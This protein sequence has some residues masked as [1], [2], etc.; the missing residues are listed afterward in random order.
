MFAVAGA[1]G[2]QGATAALQAAEA[3]DRPGD[4]AAGRRRRLLRV[5][6][7]APGDKHNR[8]IRHGGDPQRRRDGVPDQHQQPA[9]DH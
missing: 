7:A 1:E 4:D 6:P 2:E 5:Q 3:R 9:G 8:D